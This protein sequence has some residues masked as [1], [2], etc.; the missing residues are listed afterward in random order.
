MHTLEK[1]RNFLPRLGR[2]DIFFYLLIWLMILLFV[3]TIS[4]K[5]LGLYQSQQLFFSSFI[6]WVGGILPVPGGYSI[7]TLIFI[8]LLTKLV[9]ERWTIKKAGTLIV[10]SGALLLLLGGFLTAAFSSEGSMIID[11]GSSSNFVT[12]YHLHELAITE[13]KPNNPTDIAF[14]QDLL[15][16][17]QTL[18]DP[19]LPM[20]IKIQQ[21]FNNTAVSPRTET[22]MDGTVHGMLVAN[23]MTAAPLSPEE[24]Q[25][26]AGII[27]SVSS[28]NPAINGQYGLFEDMPIDQHI[29]IAGKKYVVTLRRKHTILPFTVKLIKF[30]KQQYPGTDKPRSFQSE[31][32][33]S[34]GDLQWHSLISMN[35]P[36]RYKGYTFYQSSFIEGESKQTT[37]LAVVKNLGAIFP[38][39]SSITICI[40]LLIHLFIRI[41]SLKLSRKTT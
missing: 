16:K 27:F 21:Y 28:T 19:S 20:T 32:V 13:T 38:Y 30:E 35:N 1:I 36:L 10:H 4:E 18:S 33:L 15:H 5:Y 22:R 25:N 29:E 17:G 2:A 31:V 40:G 39:I 9:I 41:P 12:A 6:I 11:E 23:D 7:Q 14:S 8:N 3:G 37:V 34:D 26:H 24:E